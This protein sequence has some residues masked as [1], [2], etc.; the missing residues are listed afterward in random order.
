[1]EHCL[2][3]FFL[4]LQIGGGT[5]WTGTIEKLALPGVLF[6][7]IT[8]TKDWFYD[9]LQPWVHYIPVNSDLTDLREKFEWAE[10]HPVEAQKIAEAGTEFARWIGTPEGFGELYQQNL[11]APLKGIIDAYQPSPDA[12]DAGKSVLDII[13][14]KGSPEYTIVSRCSGSEKYSCRDLNGKIPN[15]N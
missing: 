9:R 2:L 15:G 3:S 14:E 6:H 5:S 1:M 8:P 10:S 7:H 13:K 12:S 11:V 4:A